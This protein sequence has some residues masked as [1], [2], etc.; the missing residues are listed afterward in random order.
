MRSPDL[1][2]CLRASVIAFRLGMSARANQE[3][4]GVVDELAAAMA[5]DT[6]VSLE[7]APIL[8]ELVAAQE[9]GDGLR[10]ADLLQYEVAPRRL[11][12]DST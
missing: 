10:V 12:D 8:G 11:G 2:R 7:L 1:E 4:V 3:L 9:R 5:E 6:A